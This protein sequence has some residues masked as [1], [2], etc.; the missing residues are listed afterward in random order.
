MVESPHTIDLDVAASQSEERNEDVRRH[1]RQEM[2]QLA[3]I[4]TL[5]G[6]DVAG[7]NANC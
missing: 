6:G 3:S 5:V 2:Q 7:H 1:M 4:A